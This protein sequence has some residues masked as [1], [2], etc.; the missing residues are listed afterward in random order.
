[1][2][3]EQGVKV[4]FE[5]F[6]RLPEAVPGAVIFAV[7]VDGAAI[8]LDG[9]VG[10]FH[11][12]VLVAHQSPGGEEVAIK[13][14]GAAKV[15]DRFFVLGFQRVVVAYDTTGFGAEFVGGGGE[16]GEEGEFGAG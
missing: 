16:L 7:D 4:H 10:V 3:V 9:S 1:M 5:D 12:N 2:V 13:G 15:V 14:E 11:L 6:V 8:A